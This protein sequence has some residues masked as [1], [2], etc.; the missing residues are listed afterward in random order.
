MQTL[1]ALRNLLGA[2]CVGGVGAA[3]LSSSEA[4]AAEEK[5]ALDK[6]PP[7]VFAAAKKAV[8]NVV[9]KEAT[10]ETVAGDVSYHVI[11]VIDKKRLVIVEVDKDG[12]IEEVNTQIDVS[13]VPKAV[14]KALKNKVPK[15]KVLVVFEVRDQ[16]GKI[17]EYEF[18]CTRPREPKKPGK[19]GK[20]KKPKDEEITVTVS[21]DG[22]TAEVEGE[23][24]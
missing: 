15:A 18:D 2:A 20:P 8:P 14:M 16:D 24:D 11:G 9:W 10:K 6:L 19:P 5:V 4:A 12:D 22:K 3:L 21:P 1:P 7:A 13:E 17:T 23:D